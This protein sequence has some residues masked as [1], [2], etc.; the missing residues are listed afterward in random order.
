M[1]DP[2]GAL[3]DPTK[4]PMLKGPARG[5]YSLWHRLASEAL[6][7]VSTRSDPARDN[8]LLDT[9]KECGERALELA[10]ND[11][12]VE[13]TG[14]LIEAVERMRARCVGCESTP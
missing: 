14:K 4:D 7:Y 11:M 10:T 1:G 8:Q 12:Q 13:L 9:A 5:T 6:V 2:L 3:P